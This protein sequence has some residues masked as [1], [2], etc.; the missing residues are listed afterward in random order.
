MVRT[1]VWPVWVLALQHSQ[2]FRGDL[3]S[4]GSAYQPPSSSHV[5]RGLHAANGTTATRVVDPT[6][7]GNE[8]SVEPSLTQ[9]SDPRLFHERSSASGMMV[10][11]QADPAQTSAVNYAAL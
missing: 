11:K 3:E 4:V 6:S 9:R 1:L 10:P 8:V 5:Q 7:S 2:P